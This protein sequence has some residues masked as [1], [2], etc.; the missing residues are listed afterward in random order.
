MLSISFTQPPFIGDSQ[1][2][3]TQIARVADHQDPPAH[4][5][6]SGHILWRPLGYV[7][8]PLARKTIPDQVAWS[9]E[10]K[11]Y[12]GLALLNIACGLLSAWLI[13]DMGRRLS[14]SMA[15]AVVLVLLFVWGD[16][17]L[18]YSQ[19]A[20]SYMAGLAALNAGLWLQIAPRAFGKVEAACSGVLFALAALFWLPYVVVFPAACCAALLMRPRFESRRRVQC[21]VLSAA[22]AGMSLLAAVLSAA[23]LAG[24]HSVSEGVRWF[25]AAAHGMHQHGQL[26]RAVTGCSR[27]LFDLGRDGI[28]FKRFLFHD[29]YHVVTVTALIGY[30]LWK[31]L[32]FYV[33]LGSAFWMAWCS[34]R[35]R[36]ALVLLSL[37]AAPALFA[38]LVVFEPS[39]PERFLPVLPFLLLSIAAAWSGARASSSGRGAVIA[40]SAFALLLPLANLRAFVSPDT[41]Y[42]AQAAAQV[43][44]LHANASSS[45]AVYT[46]TMAEPLE[47][48]SLHP[49]D[50]LN[51]AQP[52]SPNWIIDGMRSDLSQWRSRF[53]RLVESDWAQARAVWVEKAA[54][55]DAPPGS[56][57][58]VEGD[59]Q[60]I[61]WRDVPAF[62]H[63]LEFDR[64]IGGA[65]GFLRLAPS[66]ANQARFRGLESVNR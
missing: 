43:A 30:S 46:V 20:T 6:E 15:A 29:P 50:P 11:I 31:V 23:A 24:V 64:A 39:S 35:G 56:L 65:D 40:V 47:D 7:A 32:L 66:A 10:L 45:D 59:E 62:F 34:P 48:L 60:T 33:F 21:T 44:A 63:E 1:Y 19:S 9:P 38:A 54:L 53:A 52:A 58:W 27:L 55:A 5:W 12:S 2:Y 4:L 36:N 57:D 18:A 3:V 26:I 17:V 14:G 51:R 61:R 49:F 25:S 41:G 37:A 28:Y 13:F 22:V 42:H 8:A 16:A